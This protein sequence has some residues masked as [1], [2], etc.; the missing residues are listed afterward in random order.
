MEHQDRRLTLMVA[1]WLDRAENL[2]GGDFC[3][4]GPATEAALQPK[5][6]AAGQTP[7]AERSEGL[8]W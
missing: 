1:S 8:H 2:D 3:G 7:S 4:G 5:W 6:Q